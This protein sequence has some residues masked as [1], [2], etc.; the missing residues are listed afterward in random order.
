MRNA[1]RE[2]VFLVAL[3][4]EKFPFIGES[5]GI[6][7][8]AG[9]LKSRFK[10]I[11][12]TTIDL[13][14]YTLEQLIEL[15]KTN[16]P[17]IVGISVK[18]QTF[19]QLLQFYNFMQKVISPNYFPLIIIGNTIPNHQ[20]KTIL[21]RYLPDVIVGI[22]EGEIALH[23]LYLY[24]NGKLSLEKVRNILYKKDGKIHENSVDW[25]D[26]A[27]IALP[28]RTN[29]SKFY[30]LGGL[31][32]IEG[33]RGCSY[34]GCTICSS[35]ELL[36]S[37][38]KTKKWR[39][40]DIGLIIHDLK[41]LEKLGIK[42]VTF[43]DEDF[44][45]MGL[46]GLGRIRSLAEEIIGNKIKINFKIISRINSIF[47]DKDSIEIQW[48]KEK[49]LEC[50]KIAG[51]VKVAMG[52]ESG[53]ETQLKRFGKDFHLS[54]F[55]GA[56]QLLKKLSIS[57]ELGFILVDPLMSFEELKQNVFFLENEDII[58]PVSAVF[59]ELRIEAGH[60][61]VNLV[62]KAEKS[63]GKTILGEFDFNFQN[64]RIISYVDENVD[65]I[66]K[67]MRE[68]TDIMYKLYYVFRIRTY[69]SEN[70]L[71]E[72]PTFHPDKN[73]FFRTIKDLK[74]L[75]F[76]LVKE[77]IYLVEGTGEDMN[78]ACLILIQYEKERRNIIE[79]MLQY[80][81]PTP[82]TFQTENLHNEIVEYTNKSKEFLKKLNTSAN[83][84]YC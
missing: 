16:R 35:N 6:S 62:R 22:G 31:V 13:Q 58:E 5:H 26:G 84:V 53:V 71:D 28:D 67:F 61:F 2:K 29:S 73:I 57:L 41:N 66:V 72:E 15:I 49:T 76:N 34:G 4:T 3:H 51:L 14:L 10:N 79:Q 75:E 60:P 7:A 40:R 1:T 63:T 24:M 18:L 45:G 39:Q 21:D 77:L 43:S 9:Y 32:F 69:Y 50:L 33:S 52:L 80:L 25:L 82:V 44:F 11:Q 65:F 27:D 78:G 47:N 12:V 17:A 81:K 30:Q 23:D 20:G 70:S 68:W 55:K 59:K 42:Q 74:Y 56:F 19:N 64:Y 54:N 48:E 83:V 37:K 38:I 46:D 36:G 8:I